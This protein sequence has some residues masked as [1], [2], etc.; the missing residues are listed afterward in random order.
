MNQETVTPTGHWVTVVLCAVFQV[1][2]CLVTSCMLQHQLTSATVP[3]LCN[4]EEASYL[5]VWSSFSETGSVVNCNTA[6]GV[7]LC[8]VDSCASASTGTPQCAQSE[9][10]PHKCSCFLVRVGALVWLAGTRCIFMVGGRACLSLFIP[11]L[12]PP[13]AGAWATTGETGRSTSLPVLFGC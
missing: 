13:R 6:T 12:P 8:S 9:L 10:Q 7:L 11:P 5:P 4:S 2:L 1:V 3:E